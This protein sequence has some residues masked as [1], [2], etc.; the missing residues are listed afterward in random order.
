MLTDLSGGQKQRLAIARAFRS[1]SSITSVRR[2]YVHFR[3]KNR[4]RSHRTNDDTGERT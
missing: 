2:A 3:S 1:P 4:T